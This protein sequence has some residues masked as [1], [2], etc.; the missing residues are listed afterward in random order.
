MKTFLSIGA[1][2]GIGFA[3]AERFAREGF[4][5]VLAARQEDRLKKLADRL[6]QKGYQVT[7]AV[8]D[9]TDVSAI[10][11]LI[12]DTEAETGGLDVVHYNAAH[13]HKASIQEQ[14]I[15]TFNTDLSVNIGGAL[16]ASQSAL[17]VMIPRHSGTILLT[18]GGWG[19]QPN[20]DFI[21]VSVG[22]AGIHTIANGLFE[23]AKDKGIHVGTVVVA[24]LVR[25]DSVE[26]A[27]VAESFWQLYSQPEKDWVAEVT[28]TG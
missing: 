17:N 19:I 13:L 14:D 18:G 3:T 27:G 7:T 16:A 4:R 10:E 9:V 2:P 24:A 12:K 5:V 11:N 25:P 20:P 6:I 26:S 28:F 21:S 23:Y 15:A 1:G 22:K 8:L